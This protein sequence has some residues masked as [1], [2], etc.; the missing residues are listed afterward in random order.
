[1]E[2][3]VA[4]AVELIGIRSTADRPADLRHA[5]D[6]VLDLV[7]P[8]FDTRHFV[9]NGKPSA[10]LTT[11]DRPQVILNAHLDVV[12][13][14]PSQFAARRDGDRLYGR[15]AQDMKVAALVMA[16]VFRDVARTLP[17]PVGLQLVTDEEVGGFDGTGHQ[18]AAGV[19]ARFVVIGEQSA[20]RVVAASK[21]IL[22]ARLT[23]TGRTAHAAYPW[24]GENALL[25]VVDAVSRVVARY[26]VPDAEAWTT[27]VNVA[28]ITTSNTAANIVPADAQA[29]LD[30]RF[31]PHDTDFTGRE[32]AEIVAH[33]AAITGPAVDVTIEGLGA[34]HYANPDSAPV[35]LLQQAA[36]SVGYDGSL[37]R[38]HGAADGRFYSARGVDACIF[39]PAGDGQHGPHEYVD[40]R[41]LRPY[42]DALRTFLLSWGYA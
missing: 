32:P 15:G 12:P 10:L 29:W 20:L 28:S 38:K 17:Y 33:L 39:G 8:G 42:H 13:G 24:L 2:E 27:T 25:T 19:T 40:L 4:P 6:L 35:R 23:A 30:V 26:P 21:G 14:K 1:M 22:R 36:Q 41:S 37:L 11:G 7:G 9:A 31:P 16:T 3:L 34:P 5:L 18:V